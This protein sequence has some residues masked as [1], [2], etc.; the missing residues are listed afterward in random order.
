[1]VI[2]K[3]VIEDDIRGLRIWRKT[4]YTTQAT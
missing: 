1:V 3:V 2:I 4:K